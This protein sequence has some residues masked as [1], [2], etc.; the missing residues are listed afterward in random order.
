MK[1]WR[2]D[3]RGGKSQWINVSKA[4][5]LSISSPVGSEG[6]T[7]IV[8]RNRQNTRN[9]S[10]NEVLEEEDGE[11]GEIDYLQRYYFMFMTCIMKLTYINDRR[12]RRRRSESVPQ[13]DNVEKDKLDGLKDGIKRTRQSIVEEGGSDTYISSESVQAALC[14]AGSACRAVDIALCSSNTNVFACTRYLGD[15]DSISS[16]L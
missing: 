13:L 1:W 5:I 15:C 9:E 6:K 2:I 12:K 8:K 11:D 4:R 14:A 16:M 7:K 3:N 10:D